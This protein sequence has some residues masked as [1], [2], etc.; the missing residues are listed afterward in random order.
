[1]NEDILSLLLQAENE[2]HAAMENAAKEAEVYEQDNE[3]NQAGYIDELKREWDLFEKS[4]N[5]KL[6]QMIADEEQKSEK[7][8]AEQKNQLKESQK[9]KAEIISERLKKEVLSFGHS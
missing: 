6:A 8:A 3:K 9:K 7:K 1:M 5:R 4:E 2:Y